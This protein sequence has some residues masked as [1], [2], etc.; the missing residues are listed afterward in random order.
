M[1][2]ASNRRPFGSRLLGPAEQDPSRLRV[3]IQLLLTLFLLS[4]NLIGAAIVV[5]L[6]VFVVPSPAPTRAMTIALFVAIPCYVAVAVVIGA[7]W[8]TSATVRAQRWA[9][10]DREPT[11]QDRR[12]ALRAPRMLTALQGAL[13]IAATVFFTLLSVAVQPER[14]LSTGL[15]VG[16]ASIVVTAIAYLLTEFTLR[17]IAARAL[18]NARMR[19]PRGLGAA[20]RLLMFWW[21]GTGAPVLGLVVVGLLAL[22]TDE[23]VLSELAVVVLVIGSVVL[24]FGFFV[25][26]LT[27]RA[28]IQPVESVTA[29][30]RDVERGEFG[31]RIEVYD[32][33]ELG[34]LQA[35]FNSMSA[36]L[37]ER[38]R[39]RDAFGRH[40]GRDV[41]AAALDEIELGGE[42]REVSVLFCDLVGSTA[43]AAERE[44]AEVVAML[45]AYFDVIVA[46]VDAHG[47]LVNK[48]MGDAV[49]AIFGAPRRLEDHPGAAL[50]AARRI[51]ARLDAELA[52][53][54]AGV[55]VATGPAVAGYVGAESRYE[56]TV[57]GDAVNAASRL[58]ELAKDVPGGVLA[59]RRT[60]EAATPQEAARW[61]DHGR[62]VLRGRT[63]ETATA[64]PAD[65]LLS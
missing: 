8:G 48:F 64:V 20:T 6:S 3:R 44:P 52:E 50:A 60:V 31:A 32:G 24:F 29:A 62:T 40:V 2:K 41:A 35:G 47:G 30:M 38:E 23:L 54:R 58:T 49:L 55:G 10:E 59:D 28:V 18:R 9:I 1:A 56:F 53:V 63:E 43:F 4:T 16:I 5:V 34:M 13:W 39:L 33:S 46:E 36:G 21:L 22:T 14:A 42:T 37:L 45:N 61:R 27:A 11:T 12:R 7:T 25:M 19:R 57:I 15:T 51:A 17:P 26:W 65:A